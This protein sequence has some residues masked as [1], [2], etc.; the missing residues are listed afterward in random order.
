MTHE[1]GPMNPEIEDAWLFYMLR[2]I[3]EAVQFSL[4]ESMKVCPFVFAEACSCTA[5][6]QPVDG[7]AGSNAS[8]P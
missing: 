4:Q 1:T 5:G 2:F 6:C 8:T 7:R 3:S